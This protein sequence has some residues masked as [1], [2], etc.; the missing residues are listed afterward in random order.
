[1]GP[2]PLAALVKLSMGRHISHHRPSPVPHW[3]AVFTPHRQ[4]ING[5]G[6]TAGQG[7]PRFLVPQYEGAALSGCCAG[8]TRSAPSNRQLATN[9]IN[10]R[11]QPTYD[12]L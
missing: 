11:L 4:A 8:I 2:A 6:A 9:S 12:H 10:K 5:I 3:L 1:M 7:G